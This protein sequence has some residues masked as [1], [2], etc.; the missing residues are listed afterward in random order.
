MHHVQRHM[1]QLYILCCEEGQSH[2]LELLDPVLRPSASGSF[3]LWGL[4]SCCSFEELRVH[5]PEEVWT[6]VWL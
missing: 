2:Q 6:W 4:L 3:K 5:E 1:N